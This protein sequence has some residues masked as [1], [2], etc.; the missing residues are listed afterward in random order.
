VACRHEIR[1]KG[2]GRISPTRP[3]AACP[4]CR[5]KGTDGIIT[6]A[7][8]ILYRAYEKKMTFCLEFFGE[9]MDEASR[10]IVEISEEF[11]NHGEEALMALEHFDEEYIR[12]INY[13]FKAA[14]SEHP[15]AVLLIDMVGHTT[16]QVLRG[17]EL[18]A[19]ARP[20][21]QH[22]AVCRQ[23]ADEASRFWRDRKRLGAIAARTNAFKLNEDIVLPLPALAEFARFV[24]D[25]NIEE[26]IYTPAE[27]STEIMTYLKLPNRSRTRTGSR[28]KSPRP[29]NCAG[30]PGQA[31]A[32]G[33]RKRSA[34]KHLKK[35]AA[36]LLELFRGYGEGQRHH[37]SHPGEVRQRRIVI[38]THMHAGDGNVHVNIPVFSNDRAMMQRA[39]K[40]AEDV[41]AKAVALGGVVSGEHGIGITKMKFLD[42]S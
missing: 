18:L 39:E 5:R 25:Y 30:Y 38:A 34:T 22:R 24:D 10:V 20:L 29:T 3:W 37:R 32:C 40:T 23:D 14:R 16:E 9:D 12:A 35:L 6:S 26:D 7:E 33:P 42:R 4:A 2:C 41:M 1:K 21:H 36:D 27:P 15:K 28:P 8:F 19:P 13:K 17:K 31:G 11:V